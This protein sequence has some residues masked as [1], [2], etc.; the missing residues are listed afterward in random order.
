MDRNLLRSSFKPFA[1]NSGLRRV[2]SSAYHPQTN[3]QVERFNRTIVNSLRGYLAGRHGDWDEYTA[4]I[5]FGYN[6]RIHS[7]L[8][9]APLELV[10]S[11]PPQPVAVETTESGNEDT[12]ETVKLR[13]LQQ[14]REL[15]PLAR[16]R[17][18]EAQGRYKRNYDRTVRPKND[19]IPKDAWVYVRKEVHAAGTNPKLDEQVEGPFQVALNDGNTLIIRIGDAISRV[20]SD[21]I[22]PAPTP[23]VPAK[24]AQSSPR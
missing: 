9:L 16:E 12:P 13:F 2:F 14:L 3:G 24:N 20:N 10:L 19:V 18:A 23:V 8:G 6:C 5:T 1:E 17:L 21:R 4:A 7:S 11:R 15:M 22:T